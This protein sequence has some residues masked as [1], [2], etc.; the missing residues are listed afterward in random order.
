M[1]VAV[2]NVQVLTFFVGAK[3]VPV[4]CLYLNDFTCIENYIS[5]SQCIQKYF[6]HIS[7]IVTVTPRDR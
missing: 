3:F 4:S 1:V 2:F 6:Q 7:K 5:A